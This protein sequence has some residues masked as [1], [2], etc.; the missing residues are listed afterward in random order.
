MPYYR[1]GVCNQ[2]M[3][4]CTT[5]AKLFHLVYWQK[6]WV[7]NP[8]SVGDGRLAKGGESQVR[9]GCICGHRGAWAGIKGQVRS[10]VAGRRPSSNPPCIGVSMQL[11][12]PTAMGYCYFPFAVSILIIKGNVQCSK[13]STPPLFSS[14]KCS[15]LV[16]LNA[17]RDI[18][19]TYCTSV[20]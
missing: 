14:T 5:I 16:D 11:G 19:E 8:I 15:I 17:L 10:T 7:S 2:R 1:I 6:V 13:L 20:Q 12:N 9:W 18:R 4:F 3:S